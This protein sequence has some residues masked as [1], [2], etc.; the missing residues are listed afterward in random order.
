MHNNAYIVID[1]A[2][3]CVKFRAAADLTDKHYLL[4]LTYDNEAFVNKKI[5]SSE[6]L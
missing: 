4:S 2:N 5:N 3:I 1:F 6:N